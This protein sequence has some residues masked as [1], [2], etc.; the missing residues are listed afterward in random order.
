MGC[1]QVKGKGWR[2]KFELES[3]PYS[4]QWYKTKAEART[5]REEHRK[6]LK[7]ESKKS[8]SPPSWDFDSLTLDYLQEARRKFQPKTWKYKRFVYQAFRDHAGNLPLDAITAHLVSKY[9][10]TRPSNYNYNFHRKDL[11]ALFTWAVKK[12][13]MAVNP[14]LE[15]DRLAQEPGELLHLTEEEWARFLLAAGP[16]RPFFLTV[17][18]TLGRVGEI[19]RLK[20]A[21][22]DWERQEIQLWTRKRKGGQMAG[23][24]L[25]M[26]DELRDTLQG[27]YRRR[28][29]HPEYI[30]IN[31]QT[32]KIYSTQRRR[33]IQGICK[34]AGVRVFGYHAIRHMGADWLMNQGFDLRT[35][36]LY[37]RHRNLA[38]TENY[39]R[40]RPDEI[41]RRAAQS[42]QNQKPLTQ[43]LTT[44]SNENGKNA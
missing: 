33:L 13:L 2:Y 7:Q 6:R 20:W 3:K 40:R 27:L 12:R 38:T 34:R 17:F 1:W 39:L 4:G 26:A 9:L 22:V 30:F 19:F 32:G 10:L 25:P 35:I 16:E 29:R 23:D 14:C 36:S 28:D 24:W 18:Y 31:P 15:I 11:G 37:L 8:D 21:D 44:L 5:A 42:L 43:P 41:L